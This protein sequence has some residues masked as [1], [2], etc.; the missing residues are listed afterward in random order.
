MDTR[1]LFWVGGSRRDLVA[2]PERVRSIMGFALYRA[3]CGAKHADAKP[4]RGFGGS[5][6][7]EVVADHDGETFRAVYTV[8]FKEAAYVLHAFQKK[9]KTGVAT[10]RPDL[11]LIERRLRLAGEIHAAWLRERGG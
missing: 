9:S 10:P 5:S 3:Q 6:V 7:L 4:L 8:R 2:F 11:E 1:P